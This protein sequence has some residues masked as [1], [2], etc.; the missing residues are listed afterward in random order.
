MARAR[1]QHIDPLPPW[2][3]HRDTLR[4]NEVPTF[5]KRLYGVSVGWKRILK[6]AWDG[7]P[8]PKTGNLIYLKTFRMV[9]SGVRKNSHKEG[10]RSDGLYVRRA[11]LVAFLEATKQ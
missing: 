2:H 9:M 7:V 8:D 4:L 5:L 3:P 11:D 1:A 6:W 10:R